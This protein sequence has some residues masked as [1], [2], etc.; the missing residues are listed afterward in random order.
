MYAYLSDC[1]C[2][3]FLC[4]YIIPR[5]DAEIILILENKLQY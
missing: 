4:E 2:M 3:C 5:V 1:V